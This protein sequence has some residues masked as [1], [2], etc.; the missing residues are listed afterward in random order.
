MPAC[1]A[2]RQICSVRQAPTDAPDD[3]RQTEW[4]SVN[5]NTQSMGGVTPYQYASVNVRESE[6]VNL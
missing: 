2:Y 3:M 4:I 1:D 5:P 6:D